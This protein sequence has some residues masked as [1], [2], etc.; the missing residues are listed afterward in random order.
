[1][2][3][4]WFRWIIQL[5]LTISVDKVHNFRYILR[6][7]CNFKR[8]TKGGTASLKAT[9]TNISFIMA[10]SLS[11]SDW[12]CYEKDLQIEKQEKSFKN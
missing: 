10:K 6:I 5:E 1:M 12:S 2:P 3:A 9:V 8:G 7:Q 4:I 11:R